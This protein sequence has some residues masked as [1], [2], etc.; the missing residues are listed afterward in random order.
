MH[1]PD[2]TFIF[3][4][5]SRTFKCRLKFSYE[6]QFK[7][8]KLVLSREIIEVPARSVLNMSTSIYSYAAS[9]INTCICIVY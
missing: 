8:N 7:E 4:V 1:L 5:F 9:R 6:R 2:C 3:K